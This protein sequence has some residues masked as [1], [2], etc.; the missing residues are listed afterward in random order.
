MQTFQI[1]GNTPIAVDFLRDFLKL[2][3]K[4]PCVFLSGIV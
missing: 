4:Y 2:A 1:H 3:V